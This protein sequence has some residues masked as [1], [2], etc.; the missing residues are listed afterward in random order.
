MSTPAPKSWLRLPRRRPGSG[1]TSTEPPFDPSSWS[2][3]LILMCAV[4]A[5]P[6]VMQVVNAANDYRLNR[7]GLR[8]R[9]ARGLWGVLTEPVLH[10]SYRQ[11]LS[12][13]LPIILIGWVVMIAGVR[14]W[15]FVTGSVIV[16]GGLLTW[17]AAPSG[18]IVGASGLVFG[19]LGYLLARA[20]F[21]RR[22]KWIVVAVAVLF[23]FGTLLGSLVPSFDSRNS[24]PA[25]LC[26]FGA[27]VLVGWLLHPRRPAR[28]AGRVTSRPLPPPPVS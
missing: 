17:L 5:V 22:L 26:G 13:T 11:M 3:A 12:N 23:F 15:V 16:V 24:W 25:H 9:E 6:W 20:F 7:F 10:E 2:G 4:A 18:L 19:W 27:G 8:P 1:R 28:G 14:V 21:S